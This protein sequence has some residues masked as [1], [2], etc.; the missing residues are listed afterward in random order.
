VPLS[1][2][3]VPDRDYVDG[4]I[5]VYE[6][7]RIELARDGSSGPTS[8]RLSA[9]PSCGMRSPSRTRSGFATASS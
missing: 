1:F 4:L 2:V 7:N 9:T 3:D 5:A 6:L 8:G